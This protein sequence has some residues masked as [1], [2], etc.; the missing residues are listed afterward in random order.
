M[1]G[2]YE[3]RWVICE[4]AMPRPLQEGARHAWTEITR[5]QDTRRA[6]FTCRRHVQTEGCGQPIDRCDGGRRLRLPAESDLA[7]YS[8]D[9]KKGAA[10][11]LSLTAKSSDR[12][13]RPA[14]CLQV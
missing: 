2:C 7:N 12:A 1:D 14:Q 5:A 4:S 11:S 6:A 9:F 13:F 3:H 8:P 10:T